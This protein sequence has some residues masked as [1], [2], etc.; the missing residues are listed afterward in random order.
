MYI[1]SLGSN[2][3]NRTNY[4]NKA[5][6]ALKVFGH[7]IDVS[8][9]YETPSWGY[10]GNKYLNICVSWEPLSPYIYDTQLLTDLQIIEA[11]L[12]RIRTDIQY[13]D[14]VIDI[15][16]IAKDQEIIKHPRLE[17]PH[18]KMHL[19]TFVLI[20]LAEICPHFFHPVLKK[21]VTE[22]IEACEDTDEI[23]VYGKL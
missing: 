3:G 8:T 12:G 9:V 10:S 6:D 23:T 7:V 22:L 1:L 14:R 13:T 19:R 15:D 16:I 21:S 5:I 20:P 18:S 4:L 17:I 11:D 2:Q